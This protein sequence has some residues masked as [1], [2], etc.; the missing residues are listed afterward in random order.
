MCGSEAQAEPWPPA[1][2][3][4]FV[5]LTEQEQAGGQ[6]RNQD[7]RYPRGQRKRNFKRLHF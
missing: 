3:E 1:M 6:E 7:S 5:E 2:L 4:V